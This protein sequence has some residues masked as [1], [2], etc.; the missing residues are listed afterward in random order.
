MRIFLSLN[1]NCVGAKSVLDETV[2]G[3]ELLYMPESRMGLKRE[4]K[5]K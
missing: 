5:L 4:K 2:L 1:Q 3:E